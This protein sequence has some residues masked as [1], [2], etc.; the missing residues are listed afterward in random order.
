MVL[1]NSWTVN[2]QPRCV[3]SKQML[4]I[5]WFRSKIEKAEFNENNFNDSVMTGS[6]EL[7]S[8]IYLKGV[9]S[10]YFTDNVVWP[11]RIYH[12]RFICGC[13]LCLAILRESCRQIISAFKTGI[14]TL[15]SFNSIHTLSYSFPSRLWSGVL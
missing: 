8:N 5:S 11:D 2:L 4:N 14:L 9:K 6:K 15:N 13:L 12:F 1:C 10:E 3:N 7:C